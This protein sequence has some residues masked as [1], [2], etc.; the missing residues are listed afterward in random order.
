MPYP[1]LCSCSICH[2]SVSFPPSRSSKLFS[3]FPLCSFHSVPFFYRLSS[4]ILSDISFPLSYSILYPS[5]P[6]SLLLSCP[7]SFV[8]F[9]P[10]ISSTCLLSSLLISFPCLVFSY[11]M[12]LFPLL[13]S[14]SLFPLFSSH[15]LCSTLLFSSLWWPCCFSSSLI[16]SSVLSPESS[17][18]SLP[19]PSP[20][21][22]SYLLSL[23]L[24]HSLFLSE[25]TLTG[26]ETTSSAWLVW[27]RK[28]LLK[29]Q[30]SSCPTWGPVGSNQAPCHLLTPPVHHRWSTPSSQDG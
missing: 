7:Y 4:D 8:S 13:P 3:P 6:P 28:C 20:L 25:T 23:F 14:L 17:V 9:I 10:T 29:S 22:S 26:G 27:L 16:S 18:S 15:H 21:L 2:F 1:L 24:L 12:A 19:F 30:T 5:V 11:L